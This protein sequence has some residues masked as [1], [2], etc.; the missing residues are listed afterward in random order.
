MN[1]GIGTN[2][3]IHKPQELFPLFKDKNYYISHTCFRRFIERYG[4]CIRSTT[5]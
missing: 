2:E 4:Y 1:I 5:I 3:I